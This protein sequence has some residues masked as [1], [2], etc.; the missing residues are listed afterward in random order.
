MKKTGIV[1]FAA[2]LLCIFSGCAS[3]TKAA[4][5]AQRDPIALVS[6]VS[7]GNI[8]WKDEESAAQESFLNRRTLRNDP[9][10][11][12][13]SSAADLIATAESLILDTINSSGLLSLAD[14]QAVLRSRAYR[15]ARESRY[16]QGLSM[17]K[18]D[19]YKLVDFRDKNFFTALAAETGIGRS[20][21]LEFK[22]NTGMATGFGKFGT[23]RAEMEMLVL[24]LDARGKTLF[25]KSYTILGSET[26]RVS[27][28]VY[29]ESGLMAL[30]ESA[31]IDACY[32]FL[33][34]LEH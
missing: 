1:F 18:P 34:D 29:S 25:N 16:Q 31:F 27:N 20:M 26:I 22:L 11:A 14:N 33:E 4:I 32:Y 5:L 7:N 13:A 3:S 23:C 10:L 12:V 2:A 21:F 28:G 9:D 8:I 17:V 15:E 19:G 6:V 24:I 30:F